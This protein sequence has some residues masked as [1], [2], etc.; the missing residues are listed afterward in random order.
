VFKYNSG[1]D[2]NDFSEYYLL[3]N[4]SQ[5][6]TKMIKKQKG[7]FLNVTIPTFQIKKGE[8]IKNQSLKLFINLHYSNFIDNYIHNQICINYLFFNIIDNL[9]KKLTM[10]NV[11]EYNS[12]EF[13]NKDIMVNIIGFSI[14][15]STILFLEKN[16]I[17]YD[18]N[19]LV[20]ITNDNVSNTDLGNSFNLYDFTINDFDLNQT[21]INEKIIDENDFVI[22]TSDDEKKSYD[23]EN[24]DENK[25]DS[26]DENKK[27]SNEQKSNSLNEGSND[28]NFSE[29]S[30]DIKQ[31]SSSSKFII[32]EDS[33]S[34]IF[35]NNE[36]SK[37]KF[38]KGII[39]ILFLYL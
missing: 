21:N 34:S 29:S 36:N 25:K 5:N 33:S 23:S 11:Y 30:K 19:T 31:D 24:N 35:I 14:D 3:N 10:N 37:I 28:K 8:S 15:Q 9:K 38:V 2:E 1:V 6:E 7:D 17:Y 18:N 26:N 27:D 32:N 22:N 39:L 4:K 20:K 12:L 16:V 13:Y